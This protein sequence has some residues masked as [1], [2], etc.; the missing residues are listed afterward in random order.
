MPYFLFVRS[1]QTP[2]YGCL[3]LSLQLLLA[4]NNNASKPPANSDIYRTD[5][6]LGY[7]LEKAD[8]E[9]KLSNKLREISGLT[10]VPKK[11][12]VA[13]QDEKGAL[14]WLNKKGEIDKV[15]DFSADGDYE[16]LAFEEAFLFALR[17]DGVLFEIDRWEKNK[18]KAKT[19][20]INTNLG[21]IN[22]TEG[23]AYHPTE[24]QLWIACKG[25][26]AIGSERYY[27]RA[28]YAYDCSLDSFLVEPI[29]V[30]TRKQLQR[31]IRQ[32][33]RQHPD[34]GFYKKMLRKQKPNM[35]LQPSAIAIHPITQDIYLLCA[36]GNSLLVLNPSF[37][38]KALWHLSPEVFEQPEGLAFHPKGDLFLSSEG[39]KKRARIYQF[40]YRP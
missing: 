15:I 40:K 18:K 6:T 28:I 16:A 31:F 37:E 34:Y 11:G 30:I 13:V 4:C 10:Y 21:E 9:I 22:D 19:R 2:L 27:E 7:D 17:A 12:L 26:A 38:I 3:F 5:I 23:L 1:S 32:T 29:F 24:N 39:Q 35:P 25:S 20:V 36:A 8:E 33:M 14:Y